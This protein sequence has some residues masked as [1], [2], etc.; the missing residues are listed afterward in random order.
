MARP[1][2]IVMLDDVGMFADTDELGIMC[3]FDVR[4]GNANK[5]FHHSIPGLHGVP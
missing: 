2:V 4:G 1:D 5:S 3:P